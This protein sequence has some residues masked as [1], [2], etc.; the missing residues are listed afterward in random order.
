MLCCLSASLFTALFPQ[1]E[2]VSVDPA[3]ASFL[4]ILREMPHSE[5]V[6]SGVRM[7][8]LKKLRSLDLKENGKK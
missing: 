1:Q 2:K 7:A 5:V 3:L 8:S 4:R 6:K